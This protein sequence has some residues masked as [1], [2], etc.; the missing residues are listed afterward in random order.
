M[1]SGEAA[2]AEMDKLKEIAKLPGLGLKEV[3]QGSVRLQTIGFSAEKARESMAAFGNAV[4][5]VGGGREQL[6]GALYGLQQLANTEF[7]LGE[8]LNIIKDAIPQVTPLLKEAFG[9]AR[10][11]DLQKLG[12]TSEQVVNTII[13]GLNKLPPV[14]G[15]INNAF[16]NLKDSAFNSLAT[17]GDGIMD[18]IPLG[19][20]FDKIASAIKGVSDWFGTLSPVWKK[21]ILAAVALVAI[22]P[23]LLLGLGVLSTTILPA[24]ATG[25]T[26]L[27]GPVGLISAAIVL[28]TAAFAIAWS[29]SEKFRGVI[30]GIG[31]AVKV[32][33][34]N[35]IDTFKQIPTIVIE[36]FK[37]IPKAIADTFKGLGSLLKAI[38]TGDFKAIPDILKDLGKNIVKST[39]F[40]GAAVALGKQFTKGMGDAFSD[41]YDKEIADAAKESTPKAKA[42]S[43]AKG[44]EL[45]KDLAKGINKGIVEAPI[46]M[47][48]YINNLGKELQDVKIS[49]LPVE[50]EPITDDFAMELEKEVVEPHIDA[51]IEKHK[52]F[53]EIVKKI[54]EAAKV[55]GQKVADAAKKLYNG[56]VNG[57]KG[58][59]APVTG[60]MDNFGGAFDALLS[61]NVIGALVSVFG[62]LTKNSAGFSTLMTM[63]NETLGRVMTALAP[64]FEMLIPAMQP[65]IG[66][67]ER[68]AMTLGTML[69]SVLEPILPPLMMLLEMVSL[70]FAA[71]QP[72]VAALGQLVG[73]V[74][75]VIVTL[76]EPLM[77]P[78]QILFDMLTLV[79]QAL[80]PLITMIGEILTPVFEVI[81]MILEG[82]IAPVLAVVASVLQLLAPILE[83]VTFLFT[84]LEPVLSV[85]GFL[86]KWLGFALSPVIKVIELLTKGIQSFVDWIKGMLKK[87]GINIEGKSEGVSTGSPTTSSYSSTT[88]SVDM[89]NYSSGSSG[90]N[91]V[92][93][94]GELKVKGTD[95]IA[96][97]TNANKVKSFTT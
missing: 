90:S 69:I 41:T 71:L 62:D 53:E 28:L 56:I 15:G 86:F 73:I 3:V 78:L 89:G 65:L 11:E 4:A 38:F 81:G 91:T 12:I 21:I 57:L 8:D 25:F 33:A 84:L 45:G 59:A 6:E 16:E 80:A 82:V 42:E 54:K 61:G 17:I 44:K 68:V 22:L 50:I 67:I 60:G 36:A 2:A 88:P 34:S 51:I 96:A 19:D 55:F 37:A 13:T 30:K 66:I 85:V 49:A 32:F 23:P 95:L 87:V 31:A 43:E 58:L 24:L 97:I 93:V 5:T 92:H 52:S 26:L 74:M 76:L 79:V 70:L 72:L 29:E 40:G 9:T 35:F 7:P 1:G 64:L 94:Q 10:T 27:T 20:I 63:I 47:T 48:E 75:S 83:L 77:I 46:D 39:P 14:T 18:V